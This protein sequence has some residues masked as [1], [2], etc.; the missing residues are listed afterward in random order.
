MDESRAGGG[1]HDAYLWLE[2]RPPAPCIPLGDGH[3]QRKNYAAEAYVR[4][5]TATTD[6]PF[7]SAFEI[8][9]DL[10]E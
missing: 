9:Y 3:E 2:T 5:L 6:F 1:L 4:G 8:L 7:P 10:A